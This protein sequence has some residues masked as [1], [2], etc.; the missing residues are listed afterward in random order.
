M[1]SCRYWVR[2]SEVVPAGSLKV[3]HLSLSQMSVNPAMSAK[4]ESNASDVIG[5]VRTMLET[6]MGYKSNE[7]PINI[8]FELGHCGAGTDIGLGSCGYKAHI[9]QVCANTYMLNIMCRD[10]SDPVMY[11]GEP[12]VP[13]LTC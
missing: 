2:A 6:E 7:D 11:T 12:R 4:G 9:V 8:S 1:A 5:L 13:A 10:M 3:F